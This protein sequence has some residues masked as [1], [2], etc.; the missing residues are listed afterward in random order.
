MSQLTDLFSNIATA[1]RSK[2]GD[3]AQIP[4][5]NFASA[6][7]QLPT[8]SYV[9]QTI[10]ATSSTSA[11]VTA[12]NFPNL[13]GKK[14]F[15]LICGTGFDTSYNPLASGANGSANVCVLIDG[16]CNFAIK[17]NSDPQESSDWELNKL[18]ISNSGAIS[19]MAWRITYSYTAVGW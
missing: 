8:A 6:I 15:V 3:S 10:T 11:F 18:A 2:S 5:A 7:A 12:L 1:I 19:G 14:N 9:T 4:A 16:I 13:A 17:Y